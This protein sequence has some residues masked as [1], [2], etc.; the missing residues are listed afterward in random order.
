M[1]L[2]LLFC[3][4]SELC[5]AGREAKSPVWA[6]LKGAEGNTHEKIQA[7]S[8]SQCQW[9][10]CYLMLNPWQPQWLFGL[11]CV[12][13]WGSVPQQTPLWSLMMW[14][15]HGWIDS[16]FQP[17]KCLF[18]CSLTEDTSHISANILPFSLHT[19]PVLILSRLG[20][21]STEQE[22]WFI[23]SAL[24]KQS[25]ASVPVGWQEFLTVSVK[26]P[27]SPLQ[28]FCSLKIIEK[29][30]QANLMPRKLCMLWNIGCKLNFNK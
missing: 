13:C 30:E 8:S 26:S 20:L 23:S 17:S 3:I 9:K 5:I 10:I 11:V 14:R 22:R 18:I 6:C 27:C 25:A 28:S 1:S 16:N 4:G 21:Y 7:C 12:K 15:R 2:L 24:H 29:L 19:Q